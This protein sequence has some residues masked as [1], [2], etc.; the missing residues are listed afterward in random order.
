MKKIRIFCNWR[1]DAD[2]IYIKV[3]KLKNIN[4]KFVN[5]D[6]YTHAIILNSAMPELKISKV[7]VIGLSHEPYDFLNIN[8]KFINYAKKNIGIYFIGNKKKLP[9]PFFENYGYLWHVPF[10]NKIPNK[11][12]LMSFVISN[13]IST[14]NQ[15]YRHELAERI[16]NGNLPIDFYGKKIFKNQDNRIKGEYDFFQGPYSQIPYL[17][18]NFNICIEN[19]C[20]PHYFSEKITNAL[21]CGAIPI[22][23][24]CEHID[25]YFPGYSIKLIGNL[26]SDMNLIESI[27]KNPKRYMKNLDLQKIKNKI[28][29]ENVINMFQSK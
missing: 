10:L 24:G 11:Y 26:E 18:Y 8:N 1:R 13:K 15:K 6:S 19:F 25:S 9:N 23:Y 17:D 14:D 21:C 27:C 20:E 4:F 7:N 22:Y 12:K 2:E 5:D 3:D 16:L 29:I 28:S